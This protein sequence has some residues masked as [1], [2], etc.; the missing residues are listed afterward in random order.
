MGRCIPTVTQKIIILVVL[1]FKNMFASVG[2]VTSTKESQRH[3]A[4]IRFEMHPNVLVGIMIFEPPLIP[5][6]CVGEP[7]WLLPS[8]FSCP[9]YYSSSL[10]FTSI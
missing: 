1:V 4:A 8:P 3:V 10:H 9:L 2:A 6:I 5:I 7:F